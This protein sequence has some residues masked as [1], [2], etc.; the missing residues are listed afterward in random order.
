MCKRFETMLAQRFAPF[1]FSDVPGFPHA[2]PTMDEW[3][4]FLPRFKEND[5][6]IFL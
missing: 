1:N 2:V 5:Y 3:G 6:E 4:D